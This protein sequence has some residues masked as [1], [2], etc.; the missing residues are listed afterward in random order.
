M[1]DP[2]IEGILNDDTEPKPGLVDAMVDNVK[3]GVKEYFLPTSIDADD[4]DLEEKR[5]SLAILV[6][7][8]TSKDYLG[9][10]LSLAE[11]RKLSPKD[12][13]KYYYRYQSVLG[14]QVSGGLVENMVTI[15]CRLVSK[16][17]SIDDQDGLA[18]DIL[19]DALVRRELTTAAG[20]IVLK[21]GPFVAFASGL[22]HVACHIDFT[23]DEKV[24]I[25]KPSST[26]EHNAV[27][28]AENS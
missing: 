12:V 23:M 22:F 11:V 27:S 1:S 16:L 4:K 9:V 6:S 15:G 8:G 26:S 25:E 13:K 28:N 21:G 20:Y 3:D 18:N 5:E 7:L 24:L 19:N 2:L 10:P 14:K 17:V